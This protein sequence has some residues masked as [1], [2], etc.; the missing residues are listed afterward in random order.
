M[1]RSGNVSDHAHQKGRAAPAQGSAEW[2]DAPPWQRQ[3]CP[4]AARGALPP[5]HGGPLGCRVEL[6]SRGPCCAALDPLRSAARDTDRTACW[7][8]RISRCPSRL[9]LPRTDNARASAALTELW[10]LLAAPLV[11][12]LGGGAGGGVV[13]RGRAVSLREKSVV[14]GGSI[15]CRK[16]VSRSD[17]A[18][19]CNVLFGR[20][21]PVYTLYGIRFYNSPYTL[22]GF[23]VFYRILTDHRS[24][25]F[26]GVFSPRDQS[27]KSV[28]SMMFMI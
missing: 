18:P 4:P 24:K 11:S 12:R 27:D 21:P 19:K 15:V 3:S 14:R 6:G 2:S 17:F 26:S 16:C 22:H 20:R 23:V 8:C 5:P 9:F 13:G 1:V 25:M 7:P 28:F 10:P